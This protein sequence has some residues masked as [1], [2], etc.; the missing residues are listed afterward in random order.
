MFIL[1]LKKLFLCQ[2]LKIFGIFSTFC[3]FFQNFYSEIENREPYIFYVCSYE[4]FD[5]KIMENGL[6][7][8]APCSFKVTLEGK[9]L[10]K[11]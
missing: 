8:K 9:S 2:K 11:F 4:H 1:G 10:N 5:T 3:S 7:H 6:C